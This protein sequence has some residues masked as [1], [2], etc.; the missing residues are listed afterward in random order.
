MSSLA[1]ELGLSMF[2]EQPGNMQVYMCCILL[3]PVGGSCAWQ[4][5]VANTML[6][7]YTGLDVGLPKSA[8]GVLVSGCRT[9]NG[10]S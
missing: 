10:K 1:K 6:Y 5:A 2:G 9:G 3:L 7:G 4:S 8:N